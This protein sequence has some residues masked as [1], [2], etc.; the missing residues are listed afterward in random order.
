MRKIP[1]EYLRNIVG[2]LGITGRIQ[3]HITGIF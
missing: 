3:R 1:Q 2:M